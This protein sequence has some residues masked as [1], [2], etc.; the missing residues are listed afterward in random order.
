MTAISRICFEPSDVKAIQVQCKECG[1]TMSFT[2]DKWKPRSLTC[3]NCVVTLVED[4]S[5]EWSALDAL[6]TAL[7]TLLTANE[8]SKF[9]L[10]LEFAQSPIGA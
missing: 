8:S 4:K 6:G 9:R 5:P 2:L 1:A 10:R 7:K 3:P